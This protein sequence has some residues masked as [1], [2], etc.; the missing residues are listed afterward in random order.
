MN[1]KSRKSWEY[2]KGRYKQISL[3]FFMENEEDLSIL[4]HLSSFDNV[5][6]YIKKLIQ[7][8]MWRRAYNER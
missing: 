7:E 6:A 3:K 5:S 1:N 8:D 2:Q 4:H